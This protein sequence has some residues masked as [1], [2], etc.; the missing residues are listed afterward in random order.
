[1]KI[2]KQNNVIVYEVVGSSYLVFAPCSTIYS[3]K[4]RLLSLYISSTIMVW[5]L[6]YNFVGYSRYVQSNYAKT[7]FHHIHN[8]INFNYD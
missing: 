2:L 1:M 7:I 6:E 5:Y 3:K 4:L 8:I